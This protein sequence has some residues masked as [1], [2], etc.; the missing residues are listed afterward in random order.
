MRSPNTSFSGEET[1]KKATLILC[2]A[3]SLF[4]CGKGGQLED[5]TSSGVMALGS[6]RVIPSKLRLQPNAKQTFTVDTNIAEDLTWTV[7]DSE[8]SPITYG[9]WV[10]D[11]GTYSAPPYEGIF[12]L[13][14]SLRNAPNVSATVPVHVS[15]S[16]PLSISVNPANLRMWG[17][18]YHKL[19]ASV[20]GTPSMNATVS[21]RMAGDNPLGLV[22]SDA[23]DNA[24]YYLAP[25]ASTLDYVEAYFASSSAY[26]TI[27]VW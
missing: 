8:G 10:D 3:L 1:V 6:L 25:Y 5:R 17:G 26:V 27:K 11:T 9:G 12:R 21:W 7:V 15:A 14:V 24:A 2:A 23:S 22:F 13:K 19:S 20:W 4:G 18:N 16:A